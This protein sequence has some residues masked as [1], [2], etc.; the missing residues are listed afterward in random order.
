MVGFSLGDKMQI[1]RL[2]EIVYLL[3]EKRSMTARE[4]AERFE[5]STR[6]IY[7]DVEVLSEANIPIYMN[8]G[9]NGGISLLPDF[10]LN[11]TVLT[12]QEKEEILTS[13]QALNSVSLKHA[14][15]ALAKLG[16]LFG[17]PNTDWVEVDFSTWSDPAKEREIFEELK[18]SILSKKVVEFSY[19]STKGE[20]TRRIVEPLK[21]CYK[22]NSWY[23]YGFC[24]VRKDYRFFKLRRLKELVMTEQTF[25]RDIPKR[26][27]KEE[28][29]YTEEGRQ[30]TLK[31]PA[32]LGFRV[33]DEFDQVTV[34]PDGDFVVTFEM[35]KGEWFQSY[36]LSFGPGCEVLSPPEARQE[37]LDVLQKTIDGYI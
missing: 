19:N 15:T 22:S 24:R 20:E 18:V 27:F 34:L 8:K 21:L 35:A 25:E 2:F 37:I 10:I 32:R 33:Y 36:V 17:M 12:E 5:V 16:S 29:S 7:R 23:L 28:D 13:L 30:V 11:K 14:N 3:L 4:L 6:T 9:K 1:N 26:I 31:I